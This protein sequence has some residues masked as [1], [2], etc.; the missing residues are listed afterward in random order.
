MSLDECLNNS[1]TMRTYL[2]SHQNKNKRQRTEPTKLVP[3]SFLELKIKREKNEYVT[4]KAL[5]DS[6]ASATLINQTAVKHLKKADTTNTLFSTAAGNFSTHGKC[7]VKLKFPEFNPTA[8][9]THTV[10][11]T[12][13]LG[14]YDLIL[15]RDLLHELEVDISF[16]SKT[17]TWNNVAIDMKPTMCTREDAFHV[18]EELFVSEDTDQI[19]KIL[20]AKYKPANLKELT[21]SLPQL[22]DNQKEQLHETLNRRCGLFDGTLGL[23]K[24][25]SYK[26]ELRDDVK[27]HHAHPYGIPH[28][29]EHTFKREVERL[30]EVGVLRKINRS[31]WAAPTFLIPKKDRSV[32]FIS[33]FRELNKRIKRKPFPIP[34]IQD[35]L[36]K[37]EGFQYATSLDLNM[38]YYH[39]K[40]DPESSRLCTIVLPWGK[41]EYLKLPMGLCNS[42]DI[43]QEKMNELF[44][45]FDYVRA[46]IDD[47][48]I[49]TKGSF[50]EHLKQLDTVL[51]KLETAGLKINAS[52][53]CFAAHELEYLGFWISRDG[54][55]PLAAKVDAIKKMAKPKNRR[56]L[57]SFIK[58]IN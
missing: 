13:T 33:D 23:W 22:N 56:A 38:G 11:V 46:Y 52:K 36:L 30:C 2:K 55:Q 20:E 16:S 10:H 44:A 9:I 3:I 41:Y 25:S 17:V 43:F 53:S 50:E 26:I 4:L 48:L 47:L 34:K 8:E 1:H 49:I 21:A 35:L 37:L 27:P 51:E 28:A 12:K 7:R 40:L 5:F 32:R 42:P 18:A 58:M 15:G 54:I 39:I 19:A 57:R 45:G 29:Y 31:E 14:N 24:G 6:G